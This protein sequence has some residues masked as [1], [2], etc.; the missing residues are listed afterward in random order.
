MTCL[1]RD[2]EKRECSCPAGTCRTDLGTFVKPRPQ[3]PVFHPNLRDLVALIITMTV[4][5]TIGG[6][7]LEFTEA[8]SSLIN[9]E[10]VSR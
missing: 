8:S 2:L 7:M 6:F 1:L 3:T 5:F 9:Q 10:Q 4:I